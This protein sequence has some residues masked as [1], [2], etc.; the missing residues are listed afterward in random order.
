MHADVEYVTKS[1]EVFFK[2]KRKEEWGP[3]YYVF[4]KHLEVLSDEEKTKFKEDWKDLTDFMGKAGITLFDSAEIMEVL[5][6][7]IKKVL[8]SEDAER[9]RAEADETGELV[10]VRDID[11]RLYDHGTGKITSLTIG[12]S[13]PSGASENIREMRE[14]LKKFAED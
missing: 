5:Q 7:Q 9:A 10:L 12:I 2:M 14:V 8:E 3:A 13:V 1:G 4:E 6:A 11:I